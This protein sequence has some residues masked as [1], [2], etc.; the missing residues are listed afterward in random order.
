MQYCSIEE[1]WG[2]PLV[3]KKKKGKK[4]Y[5]TKV[6][7]Y[8]ED[9]SFLEGTHDHH[10]SEPPKNK[11]Y[12]NRFNH[13][14]TN[15]NIFKKNKTRTPN[16]QISYDQAAQEYRNFQLENKQI[17]QQDQ[18][19]LVVEGF[20]S[21]DEL[22]SIEE[23]ERTFNEVNDVDES[24]Y[25]DT[26]TENIYSPS[27]NYATETEVD[28]EVE[29]EVETDLES[30]NDEEINKIVEEAEKNDVKDVNI[31]DIDYRL[32]NLNRN[33]NMLLKKMDDS[34]FFD[35]DSQDNIHDLILFILFG[36]FMIFVLDTI[37]KIG[38]N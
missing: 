34:D 14:R 24:Q 16:V 38:K 1:A 30:D 21:G 20:E 6:P 31:K 9:A 2:N 13:S 25:V 36:V 26:E 5:E 18:K 12:K 15:K 7:K 23:L 33:V 22:N 11:N 37:H 10:C 8:I 29:T 28:T 32:N 35:D 4:L 19:N 3:K 17:Q 27:T